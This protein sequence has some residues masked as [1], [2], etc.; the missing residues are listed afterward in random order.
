MKILLLS[1]CNSPHTVK[2]AVSLAEKNID[3]LIFSF[4]DD[5][6]GIYSKYQNIKIISAKIPG[7]K[8]F[9]EEA[10]ISKITYLFSLF[11]LKKIIKQFKP[12]ILH[13]HYATSYGLLGAITGFHPFIISVWGTDVISFP[14]VSFLHK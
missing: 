14:N 5:N 9:K 4:P 1:D 13:A 7:K 8:Q 3:V 11:R 10:S 2:W 12:D 6:T